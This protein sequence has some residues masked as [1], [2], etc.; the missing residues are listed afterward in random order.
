MYGVVKKLA[1]SYTLLGR[2][3][4]P[5]AMLPTLSLATGT[6]SE[7]AVAFVLILSLLVTLVWVR[8]FLR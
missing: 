4:L 3:R 5:K 2:T 1:G 8:A 6:E 7:V